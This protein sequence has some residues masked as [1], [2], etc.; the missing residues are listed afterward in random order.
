MAE[1]ETAEEEEGEIED[2][3][4]EALAEE[5]PEGEE[6]AEGEEAA[7]EGKGKLRQLIQTK[8]K[9]V[10]IVGLLLL[11]LLIGGGVALYF[12]LSKSTEE[13]MGPIETAPFEE[14]IIEPEPEEKG[15]IKKVYVY[16]L[17]P[18][19]LPLKVKGSNVERFITITPSLVL[20]HEKVA[21]E[22]EKNLPLL[23]GNLYNIFRR[24]KPQDLIQ[25]SFDT[26][27]KIKQE[28]ITQ[29]NSV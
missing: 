1:E 8:K 17:V 24:K 28:I 29:A 19:F 9:L 7:V 25:G 22:L 27:K 10:I 15:E 26:K 23:R 12:Y 5:P 16:E 6:T 3:A 20:S 13:L 4:E 18:F 21:K 14:I 2:V 11:V